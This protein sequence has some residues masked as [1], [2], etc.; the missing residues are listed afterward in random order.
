MVKLYGNKFNRCSVPHRVKNTAHPIA[1]QLCPQAVMRTCP[2]VSKALR[3]SI[4]DHASTSSSPRMSLGVL[5]L[6]SLF[7]LPPW[8]GSCKQL[9]QNYWLQQRGKWATISQPMG[10]L[11]PRLGQEGLRRS[12]KSD[13]RVCSLQFHSDSWSCLAFSPAISRMPSVSFILLIP[14]V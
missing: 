7:T 13:V 10:Y 2:D 3:T 12:K 6:R 8:R 1:R 9:L 5:S 4:S 11:G 14:I